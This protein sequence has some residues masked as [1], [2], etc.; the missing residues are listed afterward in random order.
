MA[1]I[2][3]KKTQLVSFHFGEFCDMKILHR[4]ICLSS[5]KAKSIADLDLALAA[6]PFTRG[7]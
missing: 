7:G 3:S 6:F 5:Y 1:V 4:M 2:N